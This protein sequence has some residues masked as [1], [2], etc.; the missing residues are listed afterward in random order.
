M[1][2]GATIRVLRFR[3]FPIQDGVHGILGKTARSSPVLHPRP[4]LFGQLPGIRSC[5]SLLQFSETFEC[6]G[7]LLLG[8]QAGAAELR[9]AFVILQRTPLRPDLGFQ[10]EGST[11]RMKL[12]QTLNS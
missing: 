2:A 3:N 10:P 11:T 5:T 12:I 4:N 7:L 6:R 8:C 9:Q 1:N